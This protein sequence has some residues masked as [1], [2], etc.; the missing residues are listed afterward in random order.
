MITQ[1]ER[2]ALKPGT[3]DEEFTA[4]KQKLMAG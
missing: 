2:W 3:T 1:L 4:A